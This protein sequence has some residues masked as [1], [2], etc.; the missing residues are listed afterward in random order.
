[1]HEKSDLSLRGLGV[2]AAII[3]GGIAASF[4]GA[5]LIASHVDAAPTGASQGAP[6]QIAGAV[7]QS[8]PP[9]DLA[10]FLREKNARL[11]SSGPVDQGHVH[12]PIERAMERLAKEKAR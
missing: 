8:A 4:G 6:P 9:Q 11:E 2:G 5:W 10:A 7:L 3:V 12:I 1:M